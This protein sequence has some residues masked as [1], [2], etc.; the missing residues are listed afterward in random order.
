VEVVPFSLLLPSSSL[1]PPPL[2]PPAVSLS[3]RSH[4]PS[5]P[6]SLPRDDASFALFSPWRAP[7]RPAPRRARG[8]GWGLL[9]S[10]PP[11]RRRCR[12]RRLGAAPAPA[13]ARKRPLL[14]VAFRRLPR[15]RSTAERRGRG[16]REPWPP[17]RRTGRSRGSFGRAAGPSRGGPRR[18]RR[19]TRWR[20]G[21][22]GGGAAAASGSLLLLLLLLLPPLHLL[23]LVPSRA[24]TRRA[25]G[26]R[27]RWLLLLRAPRRRCSSSSLVYGKRRRRFFFPREEERRVERERERGGEKLARSHSLLPLSQKA[28]S[29][30]SSFFLSFQRAFACRSPALS[31]TTT[32][33]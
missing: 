1:P 31:T 3:R 17:P 27:R 20:G 28:P 9:F 8:D 7:R 32:P 30:L 14:L 6:F 11:R 15:R 24:G 33:A 25:R 13:P 4:E 12:R 18:A 16:D 21:G 29:L 5:L 26:K 2:L 22:G 19:P 23:L 10:L